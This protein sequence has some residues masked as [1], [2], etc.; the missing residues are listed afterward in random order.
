MATTTPALASATYKDQIREIVVPKITHLMLDKIVTGI[1]QSIPNNVGTT[2]SW[3]DVIQ[4]DVSAFSAGA[5]TRITVPAGYNHCRVMAHVEWATNGT[6]YRSFRI[7][8]DGSA[9]TEP[10][11]S[12]TDV[13]TANGTITDHQNVN[14]VWMD[15]TP[16]QYMEVL[17]RQNSGGALDAT[18]P[19]TRIVVEWYP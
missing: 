10:N 9:A 19:A 11:Y 12:P 3:V 2:L 4:D 13:R 5:P 7:N 15:V 17:V 8:F 16:A 6:G 1:N 18:Y 14:S